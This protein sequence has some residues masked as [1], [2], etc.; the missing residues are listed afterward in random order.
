[1]TVSRLGTTTGR[2]AECFFSIQGE[3]VTAGVP[4]IFV[5][6]QGCS[7]GCSWCDTKY[8]WDADE[9]H[10]T[11]LTDIL[12]TVATFACRRVVVTGGEPLESSLFVPLVERLKASNYTIEV[13]TSG[14][15]PPPPAAA[16][17]QWNVSVK[18][19]NSGVPDL[20]LAGRPHPPDARGGASQ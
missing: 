9:G 2:V 20:L 17:D 13:E 1:V 8:S 3:G 7:V 12:S 11:T 14:T 18:L 6:L 5:R 19:E 10:S 15:V 16:A 4:A